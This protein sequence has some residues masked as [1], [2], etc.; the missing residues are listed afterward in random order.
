MAKSNLTSRERAKL[1]H[2]IHAELRV[3]MLQIEDAQ[4]KVSLLLDELNALALEASE[5]VR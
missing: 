2:A 4:R 3:A 5:E 1:A